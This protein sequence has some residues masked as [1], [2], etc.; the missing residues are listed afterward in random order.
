MTADVRSPDGGTRR[1]RLRAA[2]G[3]RRAGAYSGR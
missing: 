3:G 2:G 1:V